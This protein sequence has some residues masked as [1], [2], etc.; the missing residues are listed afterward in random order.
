MANDFDVDAA[1]HDKSANLEVDLNPARQ[2]V[3]SVVEA[4][5]EGREFP[6]RRSRSGGTRT[7]AAHHRRTR[8]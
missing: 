3:A 7:E 1:H 4:A 8:R 6:R 2:T 5:H